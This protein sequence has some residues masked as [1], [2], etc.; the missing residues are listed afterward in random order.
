[1]LNTNATVSPSE[2][3]AGVDVSKA[4]LDLCIRPLGFERSF[5]NDRK[6][7]KAL[8]RALLDRPVALVVLEASG[9][10]ERAALAVLAEAGLPVFRA[11]PKRVRRYAQAA[12]VLAKTDRLD[13]RVLADFARDLRPALRPLPER[14]LLE[15]AE[16][17]QR[18]AQLVELKGVEDNRIETANA[19]EALRSIEAVVAALEGEI[20][21]VEAEIARRIA[22]RPDWEARVRLLASVPGVGD[23]TSQTL[24]AEL[25]ELGSLGRGEIASLA[26]LA[27]FARESGALKGKRFIRGGRASVR[28]ALY[29]AALVAVRWNPV[30]KAFYERLLAKGK[31]KKLALTACM[32]KLLVILNSMTRDNRPWSPRLP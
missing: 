8:L 17:V 19:P 7:Q 14:A 27:P 20:G 29:M 26:G 13:A 9:G 25:P 4:A 12:G 18:R 3:F 31:P 24:L 2:A 11:D 10:Y 32:R 16:L 30:L 22:A 23:V 21:R 6:G 15:L 5:P 28:K 1:M